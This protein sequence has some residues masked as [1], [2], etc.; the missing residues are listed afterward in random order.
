MSDWMEVMMSCREENEG[1]PVKCCLPLY[2]DSCLLLCW[3]RAW[4]LIPKGVGVSRKNDSQLRCKG[5]IVDR[6][7]KGVTLRNGIIY[8][9][10]Y[11]FCDHPVHQLLLFDIT[12]SC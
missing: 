5:I 3:F 6:G 1:L 2:R 8:S 7:R 12:S 10:I 4:L 11:L 9:I